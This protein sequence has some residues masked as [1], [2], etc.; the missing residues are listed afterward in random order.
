MVFGHLFGHIGKGTMNRNKREER[1]HLDRFA[2]TGAMRFAET[3]GID[4][5]IYAWK[6]NQ[7]FPNGLPAGIHSLHYEYVS[8]PDFEHWDVA[9]STAVP[10]LTQEK[11]QA[12]IDEKER[13]ASMSIAPDAI[14]Y[15]FS[16]CAIYPLR[17]PTLIS[18]LK[19]RRH[20][21][22]RSLIRS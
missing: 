18:R 15:G 10:S 2:E 9:R 17:H 1:F 13:N 20:R 11:I 3:Q 19:F 7:R 12:R 14:R 5:R 16:S 8:N 6:Y 21:T 22:S 4:G